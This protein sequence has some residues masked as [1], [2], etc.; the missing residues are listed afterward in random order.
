MVLTFLIYYEIVMGYGLWAMLP[1]H[2]IAGTHLY[3]WVERGTMRVKCLAQEHPGQGLN[4]DRWL[5]SRAH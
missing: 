1:Q 2:K 3:I 5:R 4:P